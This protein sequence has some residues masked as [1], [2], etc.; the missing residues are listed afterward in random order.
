[1]S[2]L[3]RIQHYPPL[4]LR[5]LLALPQSMQVLQADALQRCRW[6]MIGNLKAGNDSAS[7]DIGQVIYRMKMLGFNAIRLPFTFAALAQVS[8]A[9]SSAACLC[10]DFLEGTYWEAVAPLGANA[11]PCGLSLAMINYSLGFAEHIPAPNLVAPC[12]SL[13][14]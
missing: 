7:S 2:C 6:T 8:T 11:M 14:V 9:A 10:E 1:M 3:L 5:M 13:Q 12:K 4:H